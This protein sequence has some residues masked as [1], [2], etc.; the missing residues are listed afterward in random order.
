M[1]RLL[2][3]E[4]YANFLNFPFLIV[5]VKPGGIFRVTPK[6]GISPRISE[7]DPRPMLLAYY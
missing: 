3:C 5:I 2:A 7:F 6:P 4:K 1:D